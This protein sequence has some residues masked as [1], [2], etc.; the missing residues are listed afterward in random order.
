MQES[1]KRYWSARCQ[2]K[3]KDPFILGTL[4]AEVQMKDHELKPLFQ[5]LWDKI[6]PHPFP[7][8][9]MPSPGMVIFIKEE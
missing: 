2:Y 5:E 7:D 6:N 8:S 1:N 3:D 4:V 9:F